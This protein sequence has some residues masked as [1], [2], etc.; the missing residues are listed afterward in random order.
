MEKEGAELVKCKRFFQVTMRIISSNFILY[1][2]LFEKL[3]GQT[4]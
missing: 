4:E 2:Y 1:P 3:C